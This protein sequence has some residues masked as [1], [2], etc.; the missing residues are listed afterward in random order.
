MPSA[1]TVEL[2]SGSA[3]G[4][5]SAATSENFGTIGIVVTDSQSP[6]VDAAVLLLQVI[7]PRSYKINPYVRSFTIQPSFFDDQ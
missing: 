6:P 2:D 4:K 1:D 7:T 5:R 3:T